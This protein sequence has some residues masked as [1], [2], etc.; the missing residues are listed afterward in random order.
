VKAEPMGAGSSRPP[1]GQPRPA[2]FRD[3]L[4]EFSLRVPFWAKLA[5][6]WVAIFA[7]LGVLFAAAKFDT[8][9]MRDNFWFITKGLWVTVF[10]AAVSIFFAIILALLG[11][12]G[13]LSRNPI[14]YGI[15]GFYTSFFRGT[16]LIVQLFL[17]YLG[18]PTIGQAFREPFRSWFLLSAIVAGIVAL[19]LNYGAYMTEIFRAGIQ[20]VSHGQS[21][22]AEAL[23][24]TYA[25][26]MRRV[27]LPQAMRVIIPP[28]GNEFIAMMKDTALVSLLGTP[29]NWADPFRR[30]TLLG[31]ADFRNLE[32]LL[33][34]AAWYWILTGIFTYFQRRLESRL[35]K[36]YVRQV[37]G[38][39]KDRPPPTPAVAA[40][41]AVPGP[42][43][44]VV[45]MPPPPQPDAPT[46]GAES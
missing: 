2:R 37:V 43:G 33:M 39:P 22:A 36:G 38:G 23:G 24:M 28:T 27:V 7:I 26:K 15:T 21:E 20:S 25:Q 9:W 11:A 1:S 46:A 17:I 12:L 40:G 35:S 5:A 6:V 42:A 45:A 31:R 8:A 19:S 34:A 13:R 3:R 29:I 44:A 4:A 18:L 32:A 30:A 41:L 14:A 16:P 10:I